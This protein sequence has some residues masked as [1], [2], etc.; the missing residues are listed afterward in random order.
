[1]Q[2]R[3]RGW[4]LAFAIAFTLTAP[5]LAHNV[6]SQPG[7]HTKFPDPRITF[8][9][10]TL[11][12]GLEVILHQDKTVPLVAVDVWYHV[13]SG[14]ELPGKSGFAHLFEHMMFQGT[15]NT[16]ED[17]H[18]QIL[19]QI[20]SSDS[21]G[22]TNPN[23]TNYYEVIPS[24]QLEVALWLESERMGYLPDAIT[25][26]SLANQRDVV[27]NERRQN[28]DNVPF[29]KDAFATAAA[30][31]PEGHPYRYLTIG[32]HE[33]VEGGSLDDVKGF[34]RKWYA[35]SN[36]TLTL[37][38]DFEIA[39]AQKLVEKWFGTFPKIAKPERRVVET[40]QIA[41]TRRVTVEDPFARLPRV[42]YAWNTP[43]LYAPGDA[44]LDILASALGQSGT[45]RL[46]KTLVLEKQL[47]QAVTVYQGSLQRSSTFNIIVD[48]RPN[49]DMAEVE[50]L[51]DE[52][53]GRVLSATVTDVEFRRAVVNYESG[54]V[55]GLESLLARAE[56]LQ[57]YNHFTANPDWI[58]EDLDRYRKSNVQAVAGIAK[59]FLQKQNRV[60]V[61]TMPAKP[62]AGAQSTEP[63]RTP[64]SKPAPEPAS[65]A[66]EFP[67]EAF[68]A[69]RPAA[70]PTR[71]LVPPGI[72][73]FSLPEG[74][75]V[76]LVESHKLP[77]I[78]ADLTFEG[79]SEN[80]PKD[81]SGQASLC[82]NLLNDGTQK[83]E[84]SAFEEAQADIGSN[85]GTYAGLDQ[86]GVT[87][88]T[89]SKNLDRTV[90]LWAET[91]KAPGLREADHTRNVQ[92]TLA[93]L[94]QQKGA[95]TTVASRVFGAVYY[96]P[97]HP[98]GNVTTEETVKAVT[99]GDCK[100]YVND[101][102]KPRGAKLYLVGDI[103]RQ[104][105]EQK[106]APA[107]AG[108][109]GAP[110]A[111]AEAGAIKSMP[112]KLFFVDV[113]G[114]AQSMI[115]L[116]HPGP[117]RQA[118]DYFP[119]RIMSGILGGD[120]ASRI[121]MNLR[122]D[123]GWAYGANGGMRYIRTLGTLRVAASVRTDATKDSVAE[124]Y[125]EVQKMSGGEVTDAELE[126]E[127]GAAVLGLPAQ[128]ATGQDVLGSFRTLIYFGLPID[129]WANFA[130]G[131]GSVSKESVASAAKKYVKPA[132]LQGLVVGDAAKVLPSLKELLASKAIG[133]GEL[134]VLDA[135]G[136]PA[137]GAGG[138]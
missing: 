52:E 38:G 95:P 114:A 70:G 105:I 78:E 120:F 33:D 35:P 131:I 115:Y 110:K 47:A 37:A 106:V 91:L 61:I 75:E 77:T 44:E 34:F 76:F 8:K 29:G 87:M 57:T 40:P 126:R 92:Q 101:Y 125:K 25:E 55:W 17:Q 48:L 28:Y 96:G 6:G 15:K 81:K 69:K 21:N 60:E 16:G 118:D 50:R 51:I 132:D 5:T 12:N 23:R 137:G 39:S 7:A 97:D 46:Y 82:M 36:A 64:V 83:I 32:L 42:H 65:V 98:F 26:K 67:H 24:N 122:E 4:T 119:T 102:V 73:R 123:K 59:K 112:G 13:G 80:D 49:A 111:S 133:E 30:L 86:Q 121:N 88:R 89:L 127:K 116:F 117:K 63:A 72:T 79:G 66:P 124:L 31:Y 129:Y 84:K 103:T 18:F 68:R 53:L 54:S 14:D 71:A 90:A 62:G 109:I 56:S 104:Q 113:P 19:Q 41:E 27:R 135:D 94:A 10:Y 134:V 85:V 22:S 93:S 43:A 1:M 74:L 136:R 58:T 100:A 2:I 20:G 138:K 3:H 107:L 11:P 99:L 108:W 9:K 130:K 45:G 128:F